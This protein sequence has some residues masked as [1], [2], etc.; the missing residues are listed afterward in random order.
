MEHCVSCGT[1]LVLR[2]C[3]GEGQVP[4]C[5]RC[6]EFRFPGF[7]VAM[8]TA[9]VNR[10]RNKVLLLRQYGRPG[11]VLL[12]G[13]V[14]KGENVEQTLVREVQEEAGL[15]LSGWS[16]MRSEYFAPTNTLMMNFVSWTEEGEEALRAAPGE[17][18]EAQWFS[19]EE[20]LQAI[21][22][23]SLAESFLKRIIQRLQEGKVEFGNRLVGA[24]R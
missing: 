5:E 11:Y 19:F 16:F 9:V 15:E 23:N 24:D 18:D 21:R 17:V 1:E 13:Y 10:D 4:Y 14:M 3:P 12:A 2:E 8:S 22:P 7:S 6:E 20:A